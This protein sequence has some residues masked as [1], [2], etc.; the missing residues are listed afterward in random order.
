MPR[1]CCPENGRCRNTRSG[2][3]CGRGAADPSTSPKSPRSPAY[4]ACDP[5]MPARV[6]LAH[7]DQV[8]LFASFGHQ[9]PH[10]LAFA[11]RQQLRKTLQPFRLKGKQPLLGQEV[12]VVVVE[13]DERGEQLPAGKFLPAERKSLTAGDPALPDVERIDQQSIPFAVNAEH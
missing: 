1:W 10:L 2:A 12:L 11:L 9:H 5:E 4:C 6:A 13:V 8:Q 3:E 7:P